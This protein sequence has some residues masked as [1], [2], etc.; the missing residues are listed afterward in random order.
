MTK[1]EE[2][3]LLNQVERYHAI[4]LSETYVNDYNKKVTP[5]DKELQKTRYE[6]A[7]H[8]LELLGIVY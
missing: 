8:M 1:R 6:A 2:K 7:K 4:Y 3:I 5:E